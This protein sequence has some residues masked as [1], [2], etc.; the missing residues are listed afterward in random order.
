MSILPLFYI[1][2][3]YFLYIGHIFRVYSTQFVTYRYLFLFEFVRYG[4]VRSRLIFHSQVPFL[5]LTRISESPS[6]NASMSI[7]ATIYN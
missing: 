6:V 5:Q 7:T 2:V 4:E 1:A 3:F